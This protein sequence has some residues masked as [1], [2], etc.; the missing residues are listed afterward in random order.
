M[1]SAL[2]PKKYLLVALIL[3]SALTSAAQDLIVTYG[4]D[5]INCRIVRSNNMNVTVQYA[6]STGQVL[7]QVIRREELRD[8]RR[9]FYPAPAFT[10]QQAKAARREGYRV[11]LNAGYSYQFGKMISANDISEPYLEKLRSGFTAELDASYYFEKDFGIGLRYNFFTTSGE[12]GYPEAT[13][14]S[15]YIIHAFSDHIYIHFIGPEVSFRIPLS[16]NSKS[17]FV[18]SLFGGWCFYINHA[19]ADKPLKF[20]G[21]CFNIGMAAGADFRLSKIFGLGFELSFAHAQ[22]NTVKM[23]DGTGS[24]TV[25]MGTFISHV[26]FTV[27]L[28]LLK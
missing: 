4:G 23:D 5:S 15:T 3:F 11:A 26:D 14:D 21:N 9:N 6:D 22:L 10:P 24:K 7:Y 25:D 12:G 8:A 28:R 13:G 18:G 1:F 17:F 20:T 16:A 27:G 2:P 19:E